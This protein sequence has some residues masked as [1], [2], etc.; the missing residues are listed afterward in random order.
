MSIV[1]GILFGG[2]NFW[3]LY[4]IVMALTR[5][6]RKKWKIP[7][8]IIGKMVLLLVTMGLILW[9]GYVSPLPFLGGFTFSLIAGIT[10]SLMKGR[11]ATDA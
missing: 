5:G 2:L 8:Y 6:E 4:R 3:L 9:R 10:V 11:H 1:S 7:L